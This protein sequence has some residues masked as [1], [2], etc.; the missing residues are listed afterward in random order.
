MVEFG[1]ENLSI[2]GISLMHVIMVNEGAALWPSNCPTIKW[3]WQGELT[4]SGS[5][6]RMNTERFDRKVE[7]VN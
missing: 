7:G 1:T 6:Q 2:Y 3:D 4:T 5:D